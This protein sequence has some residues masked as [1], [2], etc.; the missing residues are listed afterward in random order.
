VVKKKG[1]SVRVRQNV[2]NMETERKGGWKH[3]EET[4]DVITRAETQQGAEHGPDVPTY[5]RGIE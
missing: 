5:G 3:L 2:F 4:A 1:K